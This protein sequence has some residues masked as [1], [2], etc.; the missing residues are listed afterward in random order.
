MGFP[1]TS[2]EFIMK[3]TYKTASV[4]KEATVDYKSK[5]NSKSNICQIWI[6]NSDGEVLIKKTKRSDKIIS[7][8]ALTIQADCSDDMFRLVESVTGILCSKDYMRE[9]YEFERNDKRICGYILATN[10]DETHKEVIEDRAA[11]RF[12]DYRELMSK[13]SNRRLSDDC[14]ESILYLISV[15]YDKYTYL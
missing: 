6:I 8:S 13:L 1:D 2:E 12:I 14:K 11:G 15:L 10:L 7:A 3:I 4:V 5:K 9:A